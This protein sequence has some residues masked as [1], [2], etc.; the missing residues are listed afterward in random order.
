MI[1]WYASM[2]DNYPLISIEDG[3]DENEW[4]GIE[5][6]LAY[7]VIHTDS[8]NDSAYS[9]WHRWTCSQKKPVVDIKPVFPDIPVV[10][11]PESPFRVAEDAE[12]L[13][14]V[15]VPVWIR[16]TLLGKPPTHLLEIP[17]VTLS[18]TWFGQ[19]DQGDLCYWISSGG[20]HHIEPD[21][22]RP[23]MAICPIRIIDKA[24]EDLDVQKICLRVPNLSLFW[25]DGQLWADETIMT[26]VGKSEISQVRVSGEPPSQVAKAPLIS[27]PRIRI[28]KTFSA[29]SFA[30]FRD[31][32][33]VGI[34]M[35]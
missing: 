27:E 25:D 1:E 23:Y 2:A 33:G 6:K 11:K 4:D 34:F 13:L 8:A 29:S 24:P 17:A 22:G 26:Y 18:K 3:L 35:K 21:P 19:F 12:A 5:I 31:L 20:R 14:F 30:T 9:D 32:P 15:R 28:R 7:A 16:V 10:V